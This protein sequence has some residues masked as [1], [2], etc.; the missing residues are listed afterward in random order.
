M[1]KPICLTALLPCLL[2]G[3]F[4]PKDAPWRCF[5]G[6]R[7]LTLGERAWFH[8][9]PHLAPKSPLCLSS[10]QDRCAHCHAYLRV[11]SMMGVSL[12]P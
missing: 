5:P 12:S 11:A 3:F 9:H 8:S 10:I 1:P 2:L 4:F 7:A 6:K